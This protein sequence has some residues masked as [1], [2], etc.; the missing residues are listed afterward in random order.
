MVTR[1]SFKLGTRGSQ[2]A[3]IQ[4]QTVATALSELTGFPVE[5]EVILTPGDDTSVQF[6]SIPQP[7][8]FVS[9]LRDA[10]LARQ[11]DL[12]VHSYKDLPS[13]PL[14][15]LAIVAVPPREDARDVLVSRNGLSLQA[16]PSGAVVGTSSPRRAARVLHLRPD[17]AV[18]PIRGNVD[19]RITKVMQGEYDATVL[20]AAGLNRLGRL[21]EATQFFDIDEFIPAPAQGALAV[22]CR[23]DDNELL[24]ALAH[25]ND[26]PSRL[27]ATAERAVLIAVGASCTT[28]IGALATWV[29]GQLT[30]TAELSD[31]TTDEHERTVAQATIGDAALVSEAHQLGLMAG[32]KLMQTE[33]GKRL[34]NV[35]NN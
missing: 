18:K 14:P 5:L 2:L 35:A 23:S 19:S 12:V 1:S 25:L 24:E 31:E 22:E 28:A 4:S 6:S 29:N 21:A 16:L 15:G 30:I 26:A 20:A 8:V 3:L 34:G 27:L 13:Q 17:L 33:L 10:L 11:V 7:G 9:T 32:F